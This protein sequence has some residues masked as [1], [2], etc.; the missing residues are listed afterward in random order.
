[1]SSGGLREILIEGKRKDSAKRVGMHDGLALC[2]VSGSVQH[3]ESS[4]GRVKRVLFTC[5]KRDQKKGNCVLEWSKGTF[6]YMFS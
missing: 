6:I 2:L 3:L 5:T 1:V 4:R